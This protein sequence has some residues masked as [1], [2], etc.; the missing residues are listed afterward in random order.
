MILFCK[1][2][3]FICQILS[4]MSECPILFSVIVYEM[5]D[6]VGVLLVQRGKGSSRIVVPLWIAMAVLSLGKL[7]VNS[8]YIHVALACMINSYEM[9]RKPK[10]CKTNNQRLNHNP[11]CTIFF[12]NSGEHFS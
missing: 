5:R 3:R 7:L 2:F 9:T 4:R 6:V 10:G 11:C 1:H 8:T 12:F